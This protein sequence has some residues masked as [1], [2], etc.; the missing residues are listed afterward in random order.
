MPSR[1]PDRRSLLL[2]L[3][4]AGLPVGLHAETSPPAPERTE[5][6]VG[7]RNVPL[8]LW[9]NP[10]PRAVVA[11]S[12]GAGASPE[13][14]GRLLRRWQAAGISVVAPLHVDSLTSP[15]H[16]KYSLAAAFAP[17]WR[18]MTATVAFARAN[19]PGVKVGVGG[20]SYGS[21]FAEMMAGALPAVF[22][23]PRAPV[24]AVVAFSSP[25]KINPI[26]RDDSF[27]AL[28]APFL[29]LT[30]DADIV[31]GAVADWH[32][33]LFAYQTAPAGDKF[34]W[35]GKGVDHLYGGAIDRPPSPSDQTAAFEE[36]AILSTIFLR[37]YLQ[38][39]IAAKADLAIRQDTPLGHFSRR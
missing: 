33:H 15:D 36:A 16:E 23:P 7:S 37:A 10:E 38:D 32:E 26:V 11:F 1:Q 34:A 29:E 14:Y 35:V 6:E 22:G 28:A 9:R 25:G 13:A 3:A 17:R 12:H 20:H 39:D 4:A 19:F 31:P 18:D 8:F 5:I 2:A 30:G 24:D 27:K 21:L